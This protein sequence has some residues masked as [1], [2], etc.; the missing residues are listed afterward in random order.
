[1][2]TWDTDVHGLDTDVHGYFVAVKK[3]VSNSTSAK[4]LRLIHFALAI[5]APRFRYRW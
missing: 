5:A 4:M 1:M 2:L 3:S